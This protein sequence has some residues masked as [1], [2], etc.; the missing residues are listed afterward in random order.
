MTSKDRCRY[1]MLIRVRSFHAIH[2][3]RLPT[4]SPAHGAF[5]VIAAELAQIEALD[6]AERTASQSARAARKAAARKALVDSL[7]RAGE[8]ARV[9]GKTTPQIDARVDLP[10]STHD[11][12]VLTI[13]REFAAKAAPFAG[14]FAVH[15]IGLDE[16]QQHTDALEAALTERGT[17]RNER[18]HARAQLEASLERALDA[19]DTLDVTMANHLK[20]DRAMKAVWKG[21]RRID[22][23][24]RSGTGPSA[25]EG[26]AA[27]SPPE[28]ATTPAAADA[29]PAVVPPLLRQTA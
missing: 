9:L 20:G 23:P 18:N 26:A 6:V 11:R 5:A 4:T 13:A 27:G 14:Q 21:A 8:T 7:T 1:D 29:A 19:L 15:G 28:T 25:G 22:Y 10:P 24:R 3:Q 2:G 17:G 12:Q 16:L